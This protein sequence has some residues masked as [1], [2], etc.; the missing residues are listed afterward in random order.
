MPHPPCEYMIAYGVEKI[1]DFCAYVTKALSRLTI[2]L[3]DLHNMEA[4]LQTVR[5]N[6]KKSPKCHT[7]L[8]DIEYFLNAC[9]L[10]GKL[11]LNRGEDVC[12][13]VLGKNCVNNVLSDNLDACGLHLRKLLGHILG[14]PYLNAASE[15]LLY[16]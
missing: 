12:L 7:A 2:C 10:F 11:N 9:L 14:H 5:I 8:G 6:V 13:Y 1:N 4:A 3:W 15:I 16:G